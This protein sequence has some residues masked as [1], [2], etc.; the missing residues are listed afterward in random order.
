[1]SV[2][3]TLYKNSP[4][5]AI[6]KNLLA[7]S[8]SP[9]HCASITKQ[10]TPTRSGMPLKYTIYLFLT[11]GSYKSGLNQT[12]ILEIVIYICFWRDTCIQQDQVLAFTRL[13]ASV[14]GLCE[15]KRRVCT[16]VSGAFG[17]KKRRVCTPREVIM[18]L[19]SKTS[20]FWSL[21]K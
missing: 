20:H 4:N 5:K 13:N 1:M 11:L 21:I 19:R 7:V 12:V 6:W 9:W 10:N 3:T 14:R 2:L 16:P 15:K 17:E 8:D 18:H